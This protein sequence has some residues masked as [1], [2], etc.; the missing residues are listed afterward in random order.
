MIAMQYNYLNKIKRE[1][2]ERELDIEDII[3][4]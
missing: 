1:K 3:L 4:Y 2:K